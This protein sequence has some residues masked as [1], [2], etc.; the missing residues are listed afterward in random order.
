MTLKYII[1]TIFLVFTVISCKEDDNPVSVGTTPEINDIKMN[2]KWNPRSTEA[3]KIEIKVSDPQGL[4][5]LSSVIMEVRNNLD[6]AVIYVDSLYDDGAY[7][8]PEDG[9]VFARDGIYSNRFTP[10]QIESP[11]RPGLYYF[12]FVASDQQGHQ[13]NTMEGTVSFGEN[14]MPYIVAIDAPDSISSEG[15]DIVLQVTADDSN[16]VQDIKK[17]YFESRKHGGT[18][19]KYEGELYDDGLVEHGDTMAGD[20]VYSIKLGTPF[21]VGKKGDYDLLFHVVDS[22]DEKNQ[23]IP[24]KI[25]SVVN[26]EPIPGELLVDAQ[27]AIP[28]NSGSYNRYPITFQVS[29]PEGLA[30]LKDVYFLSM[31]P[32]SSYANNGQPIILQDNGLPF[33]I[34]NPASETGDAIAGDGIYTF[35]I[36]LIPETLPGTYT[37]SFYASD[38][39]GNVTGPLVR[40]V[41]VTTG[42]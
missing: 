24:E 18:A 36:L 33:N 10:V 17:V 30:D 32:D 35:S 14:S 3:Y 27:M 4:S 34:N 23:V 7:Y 6:G 41:N 42:D 28:A 9:D 5:D 13:S 2:D 31:K 12:S 25:I 20:A 37:F 15:G 11:V 29:D 22:F 1:M 26:L 39:A 19:V 16:G 38:R 40:R 8:H 21:I